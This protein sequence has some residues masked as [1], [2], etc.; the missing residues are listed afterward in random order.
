MILEDGFSSTFTYELRTEA[1]Y[2]MVFM[3]SCAGCIEMH[4]QEVMTDY[5]FNNSSS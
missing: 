1:V 5:M 4:D 2:C 3:V